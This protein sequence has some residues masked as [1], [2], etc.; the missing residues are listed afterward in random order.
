M[1]IVCPWCRKVVEEA[2]EDFPP[3]PFC[4]ARCKLADLDNWLEERY[5]ISSP[6]ADHGGSDGDDEGRNQH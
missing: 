2:P 6:L 5:R 1:R 4:S 3:R